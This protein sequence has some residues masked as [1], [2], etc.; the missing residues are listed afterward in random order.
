MMEVSKRFV[1]DLWDWHEGWVRLPDLNMELHFDDLDEAI[2]LCDKKQKELGPHHGTE[3]ESGVPTHY[4]VIDL[5][6]RREVY[7]H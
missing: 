6:L 4:A 2:V 7:P 3:V 5:G 1:V